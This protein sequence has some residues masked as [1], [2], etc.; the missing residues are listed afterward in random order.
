MNS[1][2]KIIENHTKK[3]LHKNAMTKPHKF[4]ENYTFWI[5]FGQEMAKV[6]EL[7]RKARTA[8]RCIFYTKKQFIEHVT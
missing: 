2:H 6:V 4:E 3:K 1:P 5:F 8:P 7:I